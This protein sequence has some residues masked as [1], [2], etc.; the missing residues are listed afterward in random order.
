MRIHTRLVTHRK[1]ATLLRRTIDSSSLDVF[2][3]MLLWLVFITRKSYTERR[4][5]DHT[6]KRLFYPKLE[7][8]ASEN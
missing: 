3:L 1:S 2:P 7:K 6:I 4:P 8:S 5:Y